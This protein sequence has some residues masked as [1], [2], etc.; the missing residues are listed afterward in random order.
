[1]NIPRLYETQDTPAEEK[2]IYR[3]YEVAALGFFWLIAELDERQ[4]LAFGYANLNDDE[5]AEWGY[6]SLAELT[7]I[8]AR[9]VTNW[10]PQP[11]RD[12]F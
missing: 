9:L 1:M 4:G 10:T 7:S 12:C 2:I 6:I 5:M 11:F 3:K 8:G